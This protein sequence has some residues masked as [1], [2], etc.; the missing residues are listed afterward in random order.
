MLRLSLIAA[1][2]ALAACQTT[3][4]SST[5][6]Q[7]TAVDAL[8]GKTLV[9]GD[10]TFIFNSD[11][12]VGGNIGSGAAIEGTYS[13]TATEVCSSY[14]APARLADL[15]Q[16]CSVPVISD[17]TVIFNRTNGSQSP[18]YTIEG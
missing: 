13:A 5:S 3:T 1:I 18:L 8:I 12:T 15:G 11:G 14:S 10:S 2:F 6:E 17:G 7:P 9:A 16:L 4:S